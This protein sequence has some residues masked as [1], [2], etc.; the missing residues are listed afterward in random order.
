MPASL[1][2]WILSALLIVGVLT[3]RWWEPR[4]AARGIP[5]RQW[6]WRWWLV[7][8][9]GTALRIWTTWRH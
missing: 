4:L 5:M 3:Q 8:Y 7:G 2:V 9:P 1:V 6:P